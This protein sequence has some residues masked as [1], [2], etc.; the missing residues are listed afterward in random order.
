MKNITTTI[1]I[2]LLSYVAVAQQ[3][4][5]DPNN[6]SELNSNQTSSTDQVAV[7]SKKAQLLEL[8]AIFNDAIDVPTKYNEYVKPY[9][10]MNGFPQK[11]EASKT[12]YDESVMNWINSNSET[13]EQLYIDRQKAHDELYGPRKKD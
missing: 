6:N 13:I 1:I 9:L 5:L 12:E 8:V 11:G 4:P 2:V 10:N 3:V 7:V